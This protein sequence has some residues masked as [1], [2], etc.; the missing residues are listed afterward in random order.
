MLSYLCLQNQRVTSIAICKIIDQ[1]A[2]ALN[3]MRFFLKIRSLIT[4]GFAD[5]SASLARIFAKGES[6]QLKWFA[7]Q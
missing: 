1:I 7:L 2:A 4:K 6:L 3:V 5:T